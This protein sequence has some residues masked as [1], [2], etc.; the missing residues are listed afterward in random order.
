MAWATL[1]PVSRFH[2]FRQAVGWLGALI[3]VRSATGHIQVENPRLSS[4]WPRPRAQP[5][6]PRS[7]AGIEH[8]VGAVYR[9]HRWDCFRS[10]RRTPRNRHITW[11]SPM[12]RHKR[13]AAS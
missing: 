5:R 4:K 6:S 3:R 11:V 13:V 8:T 1:V 9:S 2:S 12:R 10:D 7:V